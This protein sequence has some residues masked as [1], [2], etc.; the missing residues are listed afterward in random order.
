MHRR[1][2]R[3]KRR[4]K[5]LHGRSSFF[6]G[7]IRLKEGSRLRY[8]ILCCFLV[9]LQTWFFVGN[10]E[11]YYK[12]IVLAT[13]PGLALGLVA[14]EFCVFTSKLEKYFMADLNR[15]QA[16]FVMF[17]IYLIGYIILFFVVVN[18]PMVLLDKLL[19]TGGVTNEY[20]Y[21]S[22]NLVILLAVASWIVWLKKGWNGLTGRNSC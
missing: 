3:K 5:I 17:F 1:A 10:I 18:Y 4:K 13:L 9:V 6:P 12:L 21:S 14:H 7:L 8:A 22:V 15:M 19:E 16:A 2:L 11:I 20:T